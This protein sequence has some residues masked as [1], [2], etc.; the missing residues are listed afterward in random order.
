M[1]I[2]DFR[3]P[4]DVPV[5]FAASTK[6]E[7]LSVLAARAANGLKLS[8]DS[9]ASDMQKRDELGSTGIGGGVSI[10]HARLREVK[11]PCGLLARLKQPVDY[12][13]IDGHPVDL[14]FMLLLPASSQPD[15]LTALA[16]SHASYGIEPYCG[17]PAAPAVRARFIAQ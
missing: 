9:V 12:Q 14:V 3:A 5:D 15:Q 7:L 6:R 17:V 4:S 8:T 10:P 11:R 13:A 2:Q 1:K 16:P